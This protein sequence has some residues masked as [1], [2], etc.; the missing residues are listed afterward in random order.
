MSDVI[1]TPASTG[2]T[3]GAG[4]RLGVAAGWAVAPFFALVSFVRHAR[5]FHPR[6]P[7]FQGDVSR[8][9]EVPP[10]LH[11]LADRLLGSA[12]VR[13]S[14]ALW[15]RSQRLPDVLGCAVRLCRG[16]ASATPDADDQDLLFA[17]IRR[18]WTMAGS[19]FTT[20]VKDYLANDYF[21]VSPFE[22]GYDR[23]VYFRLH[24]IHA[25]QQGGQTRNE[26]LHEETRHGSAELEIDLST[27]PFGPWMPLL[28]ITLDR[29]AAVDGETLR[30]LPFRDGRGVRPAGFVHALRAGVYAL[31]QR[32]R[33]SHS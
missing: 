1:P 15:K 22:V 24:P 18:P 7:V 19:P 30:F 20:D 25:S 10:E 32:A 23:S 9:P 26:R 16:R 11:G 13:F 2:E 31:S 17:T 12:L 28:M 29:A 33:P 21:A 27:S 8:H 3:K 5:T 4:F 14:G 6:G